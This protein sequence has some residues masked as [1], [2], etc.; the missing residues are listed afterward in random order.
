VRQVCH[1]RPVKLPDG[2]QGRF[3]AVR[4]PEVW[5]AATPAEVTAHLANWQAAQGKKGKKF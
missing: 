5:V 2:T 1:G 4:R 3:F